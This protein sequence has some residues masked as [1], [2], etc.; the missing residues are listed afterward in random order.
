MLV[1]QVLLRGTLPS[2]ACLLYEK[3][4]PY[5]TTQPAEHMLSIVSGSWMTIWYLVILHIVS[6]HF[7]RGHRIGMGA[8]TGLMRCGESSPLYC[9]AHGGRPQEPCICSS[10]SLLSACTCG[11]SQLFRRTLGYLCAVQVPANRAKRAVK[12]LAVQCFL[13]IDGHVVCLDVR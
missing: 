8:Y 4:K 12:A 5:N 13:H 1:R 3:G 11:D 7:N 2:R 6:L 10:Q 9:R